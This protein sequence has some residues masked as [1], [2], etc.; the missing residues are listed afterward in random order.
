MG[1]LVSEEAWGCCD[2]DNG[3]GGNKPLELLLLNVVPE[4][5]AEY[6]DDKLFVFLLIG[7]EVIKELLLEEELLELLLFEAALGVDNE[8]DAEV[9]LKLSL[10]ETALGK[11][12]EDDGVPP[13][14]KPAFGDDWPAKPLTDEVKDGLDNTF[15]ETSPK[16][17]AVTSCVEVLLLPD[18]IAGDVLGSAAIEEE[19]GH[20]GKPEEDE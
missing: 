7:A 9:L 1:F 19:D 10:L 2:T 16:P 6:L 5:V 13:L 3:G 4:T 15:L 11:D 20:A 18:I 17:V 14:L 12:G 8:D